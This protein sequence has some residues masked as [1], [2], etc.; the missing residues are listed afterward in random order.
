MGRGSQESGVRS[1]KSEELAR[2]SN[3]EY[4]TPNVEFRKGFPAVKSIVGWVSG[5]KG[6]RKVLRVQF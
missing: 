1:Q 2:N 3:I 6:R 5:E 4:P